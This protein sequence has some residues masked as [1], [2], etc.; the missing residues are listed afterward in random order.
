MSLAQSMRA[1]ASV[2]AHVAAAAGWGQLSILAV[3]L[4]G[5]GCE[6]SPQGAALTAPVTGPCPP[7]PAVWHVLITAA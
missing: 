4:E 5:A 7:R 1:A 2:T 6:L 3:F